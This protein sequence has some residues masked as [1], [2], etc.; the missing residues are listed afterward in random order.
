MGF[1]FR[2]VAKLCFVGMLVLLW[3]GGW[4]LWNGLRHATPTP[5][6]LADG[7]QDMPDH[8]TLQN[9]RL[10]LDEAV[11][12]RSDNNSVYIPIRPKNAAANAKFR[13]LL[14]SN[15]PALVSAFDDSASPERRTKAMA[16]VG[17]LM[18][19]SEITGMIA[20]EF[21]TRRGVEKSLRKMPAIGAEFKIVV[22]GEKP[23]WLKG[24]AQLAGAVGCLV[25]LVLLGSLGDREDKAQAPSTAIPPA[26]A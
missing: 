21:D 20:S 7:A 19:K 14:K 3:L 1:I 5:I 23:S 6:V 8:V 9:I 16:S 25:A 12:F 11:L 4:S 13:L 24:L 15:D 10:G 2:W 18:A 26:S 17:Q 22:E